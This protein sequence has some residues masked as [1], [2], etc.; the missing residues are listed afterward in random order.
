MSTTKASAF[1]ASR[2][3]LSFGG[4]VRS[5]LAKLFSVPSTFWVYALLVVLTLGVT[6]QM[7]FSA[8][9]TWLEGGLTQPGMQAAGVNAIVLSTD[10]SVLP[11]SVLG[12]LVVAGEYST[13]MIRSTFTA[14]PRRIPALLVK[15]LVLAAVTLMVSALAVAIAIPIS[16]SALAS[17]GIDVRLDDPDYWRGMTGSVGYLV[18]IALI[19]FGIGAIAR[20]VVGGITMALGVVLVIPVGL[21]LVSGA[22]ETLIWLKNLSLLLPF[23]LGRTVSMHPGYADFASPGLPLQHPEGEWILEPWQ[24]ALGLVAW[25][26]VLLTT[27]VVL[28]KRRDA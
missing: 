18:S 24:G 27:A 10:L 9:F 12:V 3:D 17:N 23:N 5:E 20:N 26:V 1:A 11:V 2:H 6:T 4:I 8:N 22:S 13:G 19:A 15:F 28:V 7:S 14:V 21:G 16:V 25:V